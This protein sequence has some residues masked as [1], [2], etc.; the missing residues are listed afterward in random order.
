MPKGSV[1]VTDEQADRY[2]WARFEYDEQKKIMDRLAKRLAAA[3]GPIRARMGED[4]TIAV[5]PNGKAV[6][7]RERS[8]IGGGYL[9]KK[10]R[11]DLRAV[12]AS[13]I[14]EHEGAR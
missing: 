1:I 12:N 8:I 11:D 13:F 10:V 5:R 14:P 2:E 9:R 4:G 3:E 7:Y 6:L